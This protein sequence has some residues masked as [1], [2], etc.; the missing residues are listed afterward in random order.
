MSD[1]DD[2]YFQ[3]EEQSRKKIAERD[4]Q[5][6]NVGHYEIGYHGGLI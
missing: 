3:D 1:D 2:I 4:Y 6:N 5:L